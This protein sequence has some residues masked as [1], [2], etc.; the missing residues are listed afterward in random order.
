MAPDT[1]G[2]GF[3]FLVLG[4]GTVGVAWRKRERERER[5]KDR[6]IFTEIEQNL[7]IISKNT[8]ES[9]ACKGVASIAT[10]QWGTKISMKNTEV[11]EA[12][13]N[14]LGYPIIMKSTKVQNP[15]HIL[16]IKPIMHIYW[17]RL[18]V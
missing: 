5:S 7:W 13:N 16:H 12:M 15:R 9:S 10:N 17:P 2:F 18:A 4:V 1:T 14:S 11:L 6:C 3:G 8:E